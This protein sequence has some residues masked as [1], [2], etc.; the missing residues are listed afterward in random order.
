MISPTAKAWALIACGNP[1]IASGV[2]GKIDSAVIFESVCV[3]K[4]NSDGNF[5]G[6][7]LYF[8]ICNFSSVDIDCN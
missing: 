6:P 2:L 4:I 3:T 5:A 7:T 8:S 1:G